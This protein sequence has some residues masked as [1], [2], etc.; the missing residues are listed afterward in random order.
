MKK[1]VRSLIMCL[2]SVLGIGAFATAC[3]ESSAFGDE[4]EHVHTY[5]DDWTADAEGHFHDYTCD[6]T[7]IPEKEAHVDDNNDGVCDLCKFTD[8]E[9]TYAEDWTVDCTNHWHAADCGHIVAGVDLAEHVDE[10]EDGECDVCKY[11][12]EDIHEHVFATDWT[13][14]DEYH[15]HAA[16]CEHKDQVFGHEAHQLNEAGDCTVCKEHVKDVD[17]TNLEKVLAAAM[18]NNYKI[19]YGDVIAVDTVYDGVGKQTV[20]SGKTNKVHFALGNGQ[21]YIQYV[22]FDKDGVFNGV[23]E[24]WFERQE[25]GEVYGVKKAYGE[26]ELEPTA[27]D[28]QFLNGYNYIPGSILPSDSDD[29]TTLA[30]TLMALYNQ[31]KA[32]VRVSNA[33][34][35]YDPQT[36]KYSFA[37]TYYSVNT[38]TSGG[39]FYSI[40]LELYNVAVEFTVNADM[41]IDAADFSVE[42]YRDY[43][44]DSDLDYTYDVAYDEAGNC[45][46]TIT[47]DVTLKA[48]ANPSTYEYSVAQVSG[49][50]T[51]TTPYPRESL[52]PTSFEFSYVTKYEF[53]DAFDFQLLEEVPIEDTLTLPTGTY[54]YFHIGDILPKTAS[55]KFLVA[56]DFTYS[57][58]NNDP[59]STGRA[60]Y[61][62]DSIINGYSAYISCL[63]LKLRDVGEY[64]VTIAFGDI[65]K[66]FTLIVEGEKEPELPEDDKNTVNVATTDT[67]AWE[68]EYSY[69]ATESGTYTFNLPA[70]LGFWSVDAQQPE[71]DF[72]NNANGD[73]VSFDLAAGEKL[74]FN[75]GATTKGTWV[76][77][78]D[79][80]AGE[81]EG[82]GDVGGGE[83]G[84]DETGTIGDIAGTYYSGDNVLVINE[85]GTMTFTYGATVL[86][87]TYTI[88]NNVVTYSLNGNTPYTADNMMAVYFGY[89]TFDAEGKPATFEYNNKSFA[90]T[91]EGGNEGGEEG[92]DDVGGD[93]S[94]YETVIVAGNNNVVFS[95]A[96]ISA[97]A[98]SRTLTITE[99]GK[100]QFASDLFVSSIVDAEGNTVARNDDYTYTLTAGDYTISFGMF[101]NFGIAADADNSL[102]VNKQAVEE[103]NDEPAGVLYAGEEN[104]V[105]VD[106][107]ALEAGSLVYTFM[108][109]N[110]GDYSIKNST[111]MITVTTESGEAVTRNADYTYT[112]NAYETYY[113]TLGLNLVTVA[114]DY[115]VEVEYHA[116]LGSQDNPIELVMG[117]NVANYKADYQ[118][119]WYSFV[120]TADGKVTVTSTNTA[121]SLMIGAHFGYEVT[122]EEN[123]GTVSLDVIEGITYYVGVADWEASEAVEIPFNVAFVEG[124]ITLDGTMNLPFEIVAGENTAP[125]SGWDYTYYTFKATSDGVLTLTTEDDNADWSVQKPNYI[126]AE[127]GTI[128]VAMTAGDLIYLAVGTWDGADTTVVFNAVWE[129][130]PEA[131]EVT[132]TTDGVANAVNVAANTYAVSA[133]YAMGGT[134]TVTWDNTLSWKLTA[135]SLKAALP[136]T[137]AITPLQTL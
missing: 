84:G 105:S 129:G 133:V 79:F 82:G 109:W 100:Y 115:D 32:G 31:M 65:Q 66:T 13:S 103:E 77:T 104:V 88:E 87:Y 75:V 127:D 9:H 39:E 14:D 71:M 120:A 56:E 60:W 74:T 63:K 45:I 92:G 20:M 85:D 7:D 47:S 93:T 95:A 27:G 44:N 43:E 34:E 10:N 52:V 81:V 8:H 62:S 110:S 70:G 23:E 48:S 69:T 50:R 111:I 96:E 83:E 130:A 4:N 15:W 2:A 38:T 97:N 134:F 137:S 35:S 28:E 102:N 11:V 53:P 41:I 117:D 51:F 73:S 59:N 37:Y 54:A 98:A 106:A 80:V 78:V 26:Y 55:S 33:T 99:E 94:K 6:C 101:S 86:N 46:V 114:G 58:V 64:T 24:Q 125:V 1:S 126:S 61:D 107:A 68:D 131:V 90:L 17:L 136:L 128:T 72:Y 76:I 123:S 124:E 112:L 40:E 108:P 16:L 12:I 42:V 122:S 135:K 57:F 121:A 49:E 119:V 25:N 116:P 22:S 18:A 89:L 132:L 118:A 3:G 21:S 29:T 67:Y 5:S 91:T 30:N 36:G 113:V 19:A